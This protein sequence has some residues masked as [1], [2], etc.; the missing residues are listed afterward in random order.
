MIVTC[1]RCETRFQLDDARVPP[2]GARVRCSRC[3]H[4]FLVTPPDASAEETVH[5]L[6]LDAAV[7]GELTPPGVTEDLA[8]PPRG[9]GAVAPPATDDGPAAAPSMDFDDAEWQF[10][11]PE[12]STPPP[13]AARGASTVD[14][15]WRDVLQEEK[16]PEALEL[17]ALGSPESW[18]FVSEEA[19]PVRIPRAPSEGVVAAGASKPLAIGRIQLVARTAA[20]AAPVELAPP[21]SPRAFERIGFAITFALLAAIVL[22]IDWDGPAGAPL[23]RGFSLPGGLVVEDLRVR[24]IE[25]RI[26]GPVLV[27]GGLLSNPGSATDAGPGRVTARLVARG[28]SAEAEALAPRALETLR[29]H[30]VAGTLAAP[31]LGA[32]LG[33][34]ERVPFEAVIV[35]PPAGEARLEL[36]LEPATEAGATGAPSP[37]RPLPSSG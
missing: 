16:P 32:P 28:E 19:P 12:P 26:D 9:S 25:N 29:E 36:R 6:A 33:A 8:E 14:D 34:G 17:D 23:A 10:A 11:A 27:V 3:K 30:P 21:R 24:R 18:S 1:A 2:A 4:A 37:P 35:D 22:G 7:R 31:L 5:A 20:E 15:G 13:R